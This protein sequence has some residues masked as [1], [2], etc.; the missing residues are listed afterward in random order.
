MPYTGIMNDPTPTPRTPCIETG[1]PMPASIAARCKPKDSEAVVVP[2]RKYPDG[3]PDGHK[4]CFTCEKVKLVDGF[5]KCAR[6]S[7]GYQVMCKECRQA[8]TNELYIKNKEKYEARRLKHR[9]E[10]RETV[11]AREKA[12]RMSKSF[13]KRTE[14]RLKALFGMTYEDYTAMATAQSNVCAICMQAEAVRK[15]LCVDHCHETGKIRQLLCGKCNSGIGMFG[16]DPV[17]VRSALLYLE[18][19]SEDKGR[20]ASPESGTEEAAAS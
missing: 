16:D 11:L 3:V 20:T 1:I 9:A 2:R 19:H 14:I 17:K 6:H 8:I 4:Y 13:E 10:N 5:S 15:H 18:K 7:S 12:C